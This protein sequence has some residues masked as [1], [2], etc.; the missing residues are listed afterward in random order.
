MSISCLLVS[1]SNAVLSLQCQKGLRGLKFGIAL[2]LPKEMKKK[3][4]KKPTVNVPSIHQR[5]LQCQRISQ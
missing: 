2:Y 5:P 1:F 3:N 4:V